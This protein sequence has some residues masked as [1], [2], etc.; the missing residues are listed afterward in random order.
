[1]EQNHIIKIDSKSSKDY[2]YKYSSLNYHKKT[3]TETNIF[4]E[5][6][7]SKEKINLKSLRLKNAK[8]PSI[9]ENT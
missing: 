9:P 6:S 5:N 4:E 1:M 2:P 8:I 3:K 7:K